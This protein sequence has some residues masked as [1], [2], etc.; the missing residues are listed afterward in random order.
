MKKDKKDNYGMP[1]IDDTTIYSLENGQ[2]Y[3]EYCDTN[4]AKLKNSSIEQ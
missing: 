3:L 1:N 4:F 2:Q